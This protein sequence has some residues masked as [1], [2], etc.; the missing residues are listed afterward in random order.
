VKVEEIPVVVKLLFL[1]GSRVPV[2]EMEVLGHTHTWTD[3]GGLLFTHYLGAIRGEG[4]NDHLWRFYPKGRVSSALDPSIPILSPRMG[5]VDPYDDPYGDSDG[6]SDAPNMPLHASQ[7]LT[8]FYDEGRSTIVDLR[9]ESITPLAQAQGEAYPRCSR[10]APPPCDVEHPFTDQE[11]REG[12]DYRARK[13]AANETEYSRRQRKVIPLRPVD[14]DNSELNCLRCLLDAGLK[15]SAAWDKYLSHGLL[16]R[17]KEC[18]SGK[19]YDLK[20]NSQ[21]AETV[22]SVGSMGRVKAGIRLLKGLRRRDL[23]TPFVFAKFANH[24]EY[25][26]DLIRREFGGPG[27]DGRDDE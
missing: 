25:R 5:F 18:C 15:F 17:S 20:K 7:C 11:V 2:L 9:V 19:W 14:W 6:D 16:R 21:A 10:V 1:D 26:K 22:G 12:Q 13:L 8:F 23:D 4:L 27:W 24:L 3:I